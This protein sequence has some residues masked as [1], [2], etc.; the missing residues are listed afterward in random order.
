MIAEYLSGSCDGNGVCM[1]IAVSSA[2][3]SGPWDVKPINITGGGL[4]DDLHKSSRPGSFCKTAACSLHSDTTPSR[5][6]VFPS[7]SRITS[8]ARS[9]PSCAA[10][11]RRFD[12]VGE[13]PF[14]WQDASKTKPFTCIITRTDSRGPAG[15]HFTLFKTG[16]LWNVTQSYTGVGAYSTNVTF[17]DGSKSLFPSSGPNCFL[18]SKEC[19]CCFIAPFKRR[20]LVL[21]LEIADR[22]GFPYSFSSPVPPA[23]TSVVQ[24]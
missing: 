22:P 20:K 19:Q 10:T 14:L 6:K 17:S 9:R 13:D 4:H 24:S 5:R 11:S 18:T 1:F 23:R 12:N 8:R 16:D 2:G 3:M 21:V 15:P 7:P